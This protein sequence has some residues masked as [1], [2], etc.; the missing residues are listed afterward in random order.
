[1][2]NEYWVKLLERH[3]SSFRPNTYPPVKKSHSPFTQHEK[4]HTNQ[5]HIKTFNSVNLNNLS[6]FTPL[7]ILANGKTRK[8]RTSRQGA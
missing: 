8:N 3:L 4:S 1:M 2:S 5:I 6:F 7:Q